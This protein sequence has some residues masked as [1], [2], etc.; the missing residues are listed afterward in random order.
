[1][2]DQEIQGRPRAFT[3]NDV[4][5]PSGENR[6]PTDETNENDIQ[7][8]FREFTVHAAHAVQSSNGDQFA[9]EKVDSNSEINSLNKTGKQKSDD[10]IDMAGE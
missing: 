6:K 5:G 2:N 4:I 10:E 1:M 3:Q 8:N 7:P 9:Q